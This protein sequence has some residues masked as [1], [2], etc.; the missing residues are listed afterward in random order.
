MP[1]YIRV[2]YAQLRGL[3]SGELP[4]VSIF[5]VIGLAQLVVAVLTGGQWAGF[6]E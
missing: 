2:A 6:G 3:S 4:V 1:T 5:L